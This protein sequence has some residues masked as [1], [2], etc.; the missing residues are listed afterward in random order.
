MNYLITGSKGFIGRNLINHMDK[1]SISYDKIEDSKIPSKLP[2][3][4]IHLSASTNVR[5]SIRCPKESFK[6]NTRQTFDMLQHAISLCIPKF[7]FASSMGVADPQSP[8]LASKV[9]GEAYCKA[10][11]SSYDL[12]T[13]IARF[14]NVYGPCSEHKD[15][16]IAKFIKATI[17]KEPFYVYGNGTQTRDFIYVKDVV[18]RILD[19]KGNISY[20]TS[21][22]VTTI[23][24]L[25]EHLSDLSSDILNYTPTIKYISAP[26][27]EINLVKE[28]RGNLTST[29]LEQ[30]LKET[31]EWFAELQ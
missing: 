4:L 15:S 21:G 5:E 20:I 29:S 10:F 19:T 27:G 18:N 12:N 2:T 16:I 11:R 1:K 8:Y 24:R 7:V 14:S 23:N 9:S 13:H 3:T 31:F 17:A 22:H 30:G 28:V 26:P 25:I 6:K